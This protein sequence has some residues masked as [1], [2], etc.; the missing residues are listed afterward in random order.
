MKLLILAGMI[1]IFISALFILFILDDLTIKYL[2]CMPGDDDKIVCGL[3][4]FGLPFFL[5]LIFMGMFVLIDCLV[6]YFLFK[7]LAV[8]GSYAYTR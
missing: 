6:V 4:D 1:I 7:A 8:R 3:K 5:S 2:D